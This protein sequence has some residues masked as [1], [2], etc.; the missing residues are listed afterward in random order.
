MKILG[1]IP[2]RGNSQGIKKKNI[3]KLK[4]KPLIYYTINSAKKSKLLNKIIVSTDNPEIAIVAKKFGVNVPFLRP[5]KHATS[6]AKTVDVIKH[7]LNFL[8]SNEGYVPDIITILQPTSPLRT[9]KLIDKSI[10]TLIQKKATS[11]ISVKEIKTHPFGSF[12]IKNRFLKPY[13]SDFTKFYQR[14]TYPKI[15][16]PTGAVYTF[17][18][19]TIKKYGNYYGPKIFPIK[20]NEETNIDIDNKFDLFIAEM[21]LRYWKKFKKI[22]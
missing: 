12:F 4:N 2:A 22:Y 3:S 19:D 11:V 8:E 10:R 16:Y 7:T 20:I 14:Q 5:S 9:E 15:F 17:W 13:K 1:I 18:N 6:K 21:I